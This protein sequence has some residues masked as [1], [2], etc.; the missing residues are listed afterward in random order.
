MKILNDVICWT[1]YLIAS[2]FAKFVTYRPYKNNVILIPAADIVGGFGEDIMVAGF[3]EECKSHVTILASRFETRDYITK[4]PN[5]NCS[6][7][8]GR[9]LKYCKAVSLFKTYTDLYVIGADILDGVYNNNIILFNL[10]HIAHKIG[11]KT[12][13]TGFSVRKNSSNYFKREIKRIS[14]FTQIKARDLESMERL[15]KLMPN[16]EIVLVPDIAFLC[17]SP[18]IDNSDV[19]E[20]CKNE[21]AHGSVIIAYCPNT[22]QAKTIGLNKYVKKQYE[23]LSLFIENGCSVL[24]LY[25]D[26]RKYALGINDRDLSYKIFL[27]FK[28]EKVFFVDHV[29]DGY[30]LKSFMALAD[31]TLTGR[32]HFGISGY[33]LGLPMFGIS[34]YGKFEGLQ[35]MFEIS[36]SESLIDS[37][38]VNIDFSIINNFISNLEVNR[39]K[40]NKNI[41]LI[42]NKAK[43]NL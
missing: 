5:V 34:Y 28:N 6:T 29:Q 9:R 32:M 24:F 39:M 7:L 31:F 35:K 40:V 10:I 22:I 16:R 15:S 13:I 3:L 17:S 1:D 26:L 27:L 43:G 2:I 30:S 14:E 4:N 36:P 11:V 42:I 38:M 23:L 12:H 33:T 8:F 37:D 25:H 20:W 41:D 18:S 19:A 21:R